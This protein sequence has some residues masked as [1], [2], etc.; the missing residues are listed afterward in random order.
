MEN[1]QQAIPDDVLFEIASRSS[2]MESLANLR[3]TAKSLNLATYEPSFAMRNLVSG[4]LIQSLV[5]NNYVINDVAV[6]D[7]V[8]GHER[9]S[10]DFL[11][12]KVKVKACSDALGLFYC[13]SQQQQSPFNGSS[14]M[15]HYVCKGVTR[16]WLQIP[17]PKSYYDPNSTSG[18]VVMKSNPVRFKIVRLSSPK[19]NRQTKFDFKRYVCQVLDSGKLEKWSKLEKE[20]Q[21][22]D[23]ERIKQNSP[24]VTV[25]MNL[26]LLVGP[27]RILAFDSLTE[28]WNFFPTP[29]PC[30]GVNLR[31][32][33]SKYQGKLSL[34][35]ENETEETITL[36]VMEDYKNKTWVKTSQ[37]CTKALHR[38][39][40]LVSPHRL[41]N[42]ETVLFIGYF[43]FILYNFRNGSYKK[44]R[45]NHFPDSIFGFESDFEKLGWKTAED[46]KGYLERQEAKRMA[47]LNPNPNPNSNG[48]DERR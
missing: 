33:L 8:F 28:E 13:E 31:R 24:M 36:W 38:V 19:L 14:V 25:N 46:G 42:S 16:E 30:K 9:V 4:F 35:V 7:G 1:Q 20:I 44:V 32:K 23:E 11:P 21:L 29:E 43:T 45:L 5:K 39:D 15:N 34:I 40:T 17:N 12:L 2:S 6:D 3:A 18:I 10:L 22:R 48:D 26:H 27:Y 41:C 37:L 47:Q